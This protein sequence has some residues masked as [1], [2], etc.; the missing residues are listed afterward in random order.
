MD[1]ER[2]RRLRENEMLEEVLGEMVI[3]YGMSYGRNDL[4]SYKEWVEYVERRI[5]GMDAI[6]DIIGLLEEV[7]DMDLTNCRWDAQDHQESLMEE[8]EMVEKMERQETWN[9]S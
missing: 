6:D 8:L 9:N 5:K 7:L 2:I 3:S 1:E 4:F